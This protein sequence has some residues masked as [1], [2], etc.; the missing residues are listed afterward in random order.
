MDEKVESVRV[1]LKQ[2]N[3]AEAARQGEVPESTLR[4]DLEKLKTYGVGL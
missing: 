3:G 2:I 4:Y 1:A